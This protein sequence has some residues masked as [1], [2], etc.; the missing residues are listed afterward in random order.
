MAMELKRSRESWGSGFL[1]MRRTA[2]ACEM[3]R[4]RRTLASD[5]A[6]FGGGGG[7]GGGDD[8]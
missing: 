7:D 5:S 6:E 4:G 1:I 8:C 2:S 3:K